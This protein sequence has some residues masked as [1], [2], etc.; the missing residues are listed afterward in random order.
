MV[1]ASGSWIERRISSQGLGHM[2]NW[3]TYK[4]AEQFNSLS[5]QGTG[6]PLGTPTGSYLAVEI[7]PAE[8]GR[9]AEKTPAHHA[10][11]NG[12]TAPTRARFAKSG[13]TGIPGPLEF[14]GHWNFRATGNLEQ[15]GNQNQEFL[16]GVSSGRIHPE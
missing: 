15:A 1:F 11:P 12:H 3:G 8:W 4:L 14:Q 9:P 2:E 7:K 16:T 13:D 10:G 6:I 5:N